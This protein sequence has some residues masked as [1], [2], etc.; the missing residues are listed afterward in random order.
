M[1]R[2]WVPTPIF[3]FQKSV[4]KKGTNFETS[5]VASVT[6]HSTLESPGESFGADKKSLR[7]TWM[8]FTMSSRLDL[9]DCMASSTVWLALEELT[10]RRM[11]VA[12]DSQVS[13]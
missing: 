8:F 3:R 12:W 13:A 6:H 11:A 4:P 7:L 10:S 5:E 1:G 2:T 9:K